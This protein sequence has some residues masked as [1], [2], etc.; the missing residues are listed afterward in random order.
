[1]LFL[2]AS[3][4]GIATGMTR[5]AF[6]ISMVAVLLVVTFA[7][8]TLFFS[9]PVSYLNLLVSILGYNFGIVCLVAG[10]TVARRSSE[11]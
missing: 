8:S 6:S 2:T 1:M 7:L 10:A 4:L 5:C 9:G 11:A 3:F